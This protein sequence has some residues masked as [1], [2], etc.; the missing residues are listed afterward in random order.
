MFKC[1]QELLCEVES[2]PQ[3]N[4]TLSG[5]RRR[6]VV[7]RKHPLQEQIRRTMQAEIPT[8]A[9]GAQPPYSSVLGSQP[10]TASCLGLSNGSACEL[11]TLSPESRLLMST[12][13]STV[14]NSKQ[15]I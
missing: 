6:D 3:G 8:R 10:G 2:Y 12:Y 11:I 5:V 7:V 15:F 1:S 13:S 14:F 9:L 4:F